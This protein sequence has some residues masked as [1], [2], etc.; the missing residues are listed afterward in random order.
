MLPAPAFYNVA[1]RRARYR[2]S[3]L[4]EVKKEIP[5]NVR[6]PLANGGWGVSR[7]LPGNPPLVF[8]VEGSRLFEAAQGDVEFAWERKQCVGRR[9]A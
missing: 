9:A 5:V 7:L 6:Q 8:L 2:I 1:N 3:A 4:F